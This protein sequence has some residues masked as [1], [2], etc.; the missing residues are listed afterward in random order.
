MFI[1]IDRD[2]LEGVYQDHPKTT[3]YFSRNA[4]VRQIFWKRLKTLY[5]LMEH[6][7]HPKDHI[8]DFG[9]GNGVFLPSLAQ[10]FKHVTCIDLDTQRAAKIAA[11]FD[12]KNVKLQSA[13]LN[14]DSLLEKPVDAIV[15]A[16]V[17]EHF[18]DLS[19][20]VRSVTRF[21]K[22]DGFLYTSLPTEN[23]LYVLLRKIFNLKKPEDHYHSGYE[24]EKFLSANG[25]RRL[26][27]RHIPFPL[28]SLF[29]VS[30][31]KKI[32][33]GP[34]MGPSDPQIQSS[35]KF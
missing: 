15:A 4:V 8:L 2:I 32:Q 23:R 7:D 17:L 34:K 16:D 11:V 24:V 19:G 6:A 18:K 12:L 22:D 9:G 5:R 25:F 1:Q 20:P 13:N 3:L 10:L 30:Q 31:W 35:K 33:S 27:R 21:L 14:N 28:F 26:K 29:L